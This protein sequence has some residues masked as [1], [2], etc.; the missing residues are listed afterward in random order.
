MYNALTGAN[1]LGW[2]NSTLYTVGANALDNTDASVWLC[3]IENTS[4]PTGT[5]AQDR[6]AHPKNWARLLTGFAPRGEWAN[7]TQYFPYDLAYQTS[8][9]IFALCI[10]KHVS[11]P[12][13]T[14]KNDA[15]H[16]AFLCDLSSANLA[17]ANVVSYSNALSPN[18]TATNVQAAIDQLAA[19][20]VALCNTN[21][22]QG[23][24]ITTL[25]TTSMKLAGNQTITGGFKVTPYNKGTAAGTI[26]ID[27]LNGNY[28]YINNASGFTLLAPNSDCA[29]DLLVANVPGAST[30]TLTGFTVGPNIGDPLTITNGHKFIISIRRIGGIATY[31]IKALQ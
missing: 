19:Q 22:T 8:M 13:G 29:I 21:V 18:L 25:L 24:D 15:V 16:W 11:N 28:Q 31:V 2:Q 30:I 20:V 17:T 27:P 26:T 1:V 6:T 4:P 14:I 3:V 7:A 9:G 10:D 12:S 23:Q 5:F